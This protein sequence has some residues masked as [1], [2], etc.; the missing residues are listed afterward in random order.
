MVPVSTMGI[1]K[2]LLPL[3]TFPTSRSQSLVDLSTVYFL[4]FF[5]VLNIEKIDHIIY[6]HV[7]CVVSY[8]LT[9]AY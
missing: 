1:E 3:Y 5:A 8:L 6:K 9:E 7:R 4:Y 2:G